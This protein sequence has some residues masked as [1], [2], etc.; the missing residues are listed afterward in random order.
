M[1]LFYKTQLVEVRANEGR[2]R[3]SE[4]DRQCKYL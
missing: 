3:V 2:E 4:M 1:K